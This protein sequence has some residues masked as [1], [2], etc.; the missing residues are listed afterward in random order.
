ML[1]EY[2]ELAEELEEELKKMEAENAVKQAELDELQSR[3]EDTQQK[4]EDESASKGTGTAFV[5]P[6]KA[7]S[8]EPKDDEPAVIPPDGDLETTE[9]NDEPTNPI[10]DEEQEK[11]EDVIL[12]PTT[13]AAAEQQVNTSSTDVTSSESQSKEDFTLTH[14]A[15]ETLRAFV[16]NAKDDM[17]RLVGM[18]V[19]VVQPLLN[20]GDVAWRQIKALF[21]RARTAYYEN[22]GSDKG[23][24]NS[25]DTDKD[26]N[27][28][29]TNDLEE[30]YD[31]DE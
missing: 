12:P 8:G 27:K 11:E 28:E 5:P 1:N 25:D 31:F 2:P 14:L 13:T 18:M 16:Q 4:T 15:I 24:D 29:K 19:P 17:K 20:A 23:I 10:P 3:L 9:S 6:K 7:D 21:V 26:T 22:A 30:G